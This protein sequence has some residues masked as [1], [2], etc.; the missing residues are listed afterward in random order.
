MLI[1]ARRA[2][3][4]R[5]ADETPE[6]KFGISRVRG[7]R[8][9]IRIV[10]GRKKFAGKIHGQQFQFASEQGAHSLAQSVAA[11]FVM[12]FNFH[13]GQLPHDPGVF[14]ESERDLRISERSK[15]EIMLD[16]GRFRFFAAQKF[17]ARGQIEKKLPHFDAG[18]GRAAG[19]FDF[20]NFSTVDDDLCSVRRIAFTLARGHGEA[21]HAGN[22]WQRFAAKTHG[23][24]RA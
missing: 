2:G 24:Y 8:F 5:R 4:A 14:Q 12:L 15:R 23:R 21:T 1:F 22:A 11:G 6:M 9:R 13:G 10:F 18:S 20:E 3:H 16:V 17:P 7:R 19:R